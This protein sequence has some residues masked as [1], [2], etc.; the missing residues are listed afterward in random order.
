MSFVQKGRERW[1]VKHFELS[2]PSEKHLQRS[3]EDI[4]ALGI[5]A[6]L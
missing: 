3:L 2:N 1:G 5:E 6:T 4:G